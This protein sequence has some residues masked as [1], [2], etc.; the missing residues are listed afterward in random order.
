LKYVYKF[1]KLC[2]GYY[3]VTNIPYIQVFHCL[4]DF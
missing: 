3:F 4:L 2:D 1:F